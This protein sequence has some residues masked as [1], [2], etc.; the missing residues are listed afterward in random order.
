[1]DKNAIFN[2]FKKSKEV[3]EVK[4]VETKNEIKEEVAAESKEEQKEI[5]KVQNITENK[6]KTFKNKKRNKNRHAVFKKEPVDKV[7]AS[8]ETWKANFL[9]DE[10][11]KE[12]LELLDYYRS[13]N[14]T[15]FT[16]EEFFENKYKHPQ[17][18]TV[19][20]DPNL[21]EINAGKGG[22]AYLVKPL[23][24][25]EYNYFLKNIGTR[26]EKPEEFM[27]YAVKT[28]VLYPKFDDEKIN[29]TGAGT[30]LALYNYILQFSD[31]T[32]TIKILEV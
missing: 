10:T 27:K 6:F 1:M 5:I 14:F 30:I 21:L 17:M 15:V 4:D 32:K 22:N 31:L 29:R 11:N 9:A 18:R 3:V 28:G 16:N 8:F 20:L 7:P 13:K 12:F 25:D 2:E 23:Y 26:D 19:I 24:T